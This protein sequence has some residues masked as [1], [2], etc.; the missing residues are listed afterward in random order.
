MFLQWAWLVWATF[1]SRASPSL[2]PVIPLRLLATC[3]HILSSR[4]NNSNC[5]QHQVV[6]EGIC[7]QV[8][9]CHIRTVHHPSTCTHWTMTVQWPS[10]LAWRP[11]PRSFDKTVCM[12]ASL[13]SFVLLVL[14]DH[15]VTWIISLTDAAILVFKNGEMC[16]LHSHLDHLPYLLV[17]PF[18]S[19][20]WADVQISQSMGRVYIFH[21]KIM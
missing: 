9:Q 10:V 5:G 11:G 2:H 6:V 1:T 4:L 19:L 3:L 7:H 18:L 13:W 21:F 20:E 8:T 17:L 14:L 12:R 15:A 16:R